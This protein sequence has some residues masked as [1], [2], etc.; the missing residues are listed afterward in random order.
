M[1]IEEINLSNKKADT[2]GDNVVDSTDLNIIPIHRNQPDDVCLGCDLNDDGI[3]TSFD[4]KKLV[5]LFIR[6]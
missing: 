5:H 2:R 4:A 3:I 1:E 6:S